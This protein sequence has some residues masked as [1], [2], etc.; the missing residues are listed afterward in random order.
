MKR[1]VARTVSGIRRIGL[2]A[3]NASIA[4]TVNSFSWIARP[5]PGTVTCSAPGI[6]L[7]TC[8]ELSRSALLG[9]HERGH[10]NRRQDVRHVE[11]DLHPPEVGPRGRAR[12]QPVVPDEPLEVLGVIRPLWVEIGGELLE[13]LAAS[14]GFSLGRDPRE[15]LVALLRVEH[16]LRPGVE[17]DESLHAVGVGGREH[18]ARRSGLGDPEQRGPFAADR[19]H[20]GPQ[21]V[22]PRLD[23]EA[24]RPVGEADA[25]GVDDDQP[26]AFGQPLAEL[27]EV[28]RLPERVQVREERK[29]DEVGR[30]LADDLV[31]DRDVAAPRVADVGHVHPLT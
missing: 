31:G 26:A 18:G 4:S 22:H 11:F 19:V 23:R 16:A 7:A 5:T 2:P 15:R 24:A 13:Q 10:P 14:P 20:D 29:E 3:R 17:E 1:T 21:V 27:G 8:S 25:A 9:E 28:R 12:G 6:R 30:P